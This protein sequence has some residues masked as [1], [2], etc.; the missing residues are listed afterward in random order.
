MKKDNKEFKD[1]ESVMASANNVL[2]MGLWI[3]KIQKWYKTTGRIV[4]AVIGALL[5]SAWASTLIVW[6][7]T[8]NAFWLKLFFGTIA[9]ILILMFQ[10][11]WMDELM[12]RGCKT[13]INSDMTNMDKPEPLDVN[14]KFFDGYKNFKYRITDPKCP[15]YNKQFFL[16]PVYARLS[17]NGAIM[18]F[19][20]TQIRQTNEEK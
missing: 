4:S 7:C 11:M 5:G 12:K 18:F 20:T 1:L 16:Y 8:D 17:E 9:V 14:L 15:E 19:K 13:A 2:I 10:T 3:F 6:I